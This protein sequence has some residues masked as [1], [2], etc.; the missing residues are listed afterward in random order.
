MGTA[1]RQMHPLCVWLSD[2]GQAGAEL[3]FRV[4]WPRQKCCLRPERSRGSMWNDTH[5]A[6][7]FAAAVS[8]LL[9]ERWTACPAYSIKHAFIVLTP[10][11]SHLDLN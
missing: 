9:A 2:I 10:M 1:A 5:G 11:N 8:I 6:A 7:R 4:G 3:L